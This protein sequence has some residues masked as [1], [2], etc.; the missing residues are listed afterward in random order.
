MIMEAKFYTDINEFYD[1]AYSFLLKKEV[2]NGLLLSI[3]NSLKE[4]IQRYGEVMPL[5]FAL[6]EE[7]EVKL[8]SLRTPPHDLIISYIDDL[9]GIEILVEELLKQQ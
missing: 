7:G 3:L 1:L 5:L 4:N 6:K 8:I 9:N 2:E